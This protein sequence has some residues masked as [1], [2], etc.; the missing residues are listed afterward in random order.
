MM[1]LSILKWYGLANGTV[2]QEIAVTLFIGFIGCLPFFLDIFLY[3]YIKGFKGSLLL[4]LAFATFEMLFSFTFF[5]NLDSIA[6]TQVENETL[7]QLAS[8]F[9]TYSITLMVIWFGTTLL[10]ILE[11]WEVDHKFVKKPLIIYT[12][13]LILGLI[14]GGLRLA[15]ADTHVP[16]V[17]M[18]I[19]TGTY[20][21]NFTINPD[22]LSLENNIQSMEKLTKV[23]AS[24]GAEMIVFNEEAY[25]VKDTD[26][27]KM[28]NATSQAAI[29]N[30]IFVLMALEVEDTD[31]SLQGLGENQLYLY[32]N[33]G[34]IVFIYD[35]THLVPGV[36]TGR[37]V[38]GTNPIPNR[39]IELPGGKKIKISTVICLDS[40]YVGYIREGLESDTQVF[41]VPTWD[42]EAIDFYHNN[43][44][45]YR[46]VEN[47]ITTL[48]ATYD[49][50]STVID[51]Y[52]RTLMV[53]DT[54]SS[55]YENV[56]FSNVP[57]KRIFTLYHVLGFI[58]D[59]FYLVGLLG[60]ILFDPL[61]RRFKITEQ[62]KLKFK[63]KK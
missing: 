44:V 33:H 6:V 46:S 61:N 3:K 56:S 10:Y 26:L 14:Y 51:P 25:I 12:S 37:Y 4:P 40:S 19:T 41:I 60:I 54:D 43:W 55:G 16:T 48:R 24:G 29:Q 8:L 59:W 32:D 62:L 15:F 34:N 35:K 49:G 23:A 9:G 7:M 50:Y 39:L 21:G 30:N 47:G 28:L 52:G 13:L 42:W 63:K 57:L 17:K 53:S 1:A 27:D 11:R 22:S 31:R 20:V 58:L 36:E 2:I 18:A 38:K 5:S 45:I